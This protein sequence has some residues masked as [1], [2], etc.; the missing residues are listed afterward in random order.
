[1]S[2]VMAYSMFAVKLSNEIPVQSECIPLMGLFL[3][4][5]SIF[6]LFAMIWFI[7]LN[8]FKSKE[9]LPKVLSLPGDCLQKIVCLCFHKKIKQK[10]NMNQVS[11]SSEPEQKINLEDRGKCRFCSNES[12]PENDKTKMKKILDS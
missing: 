5:S 6:N 10:S 12:N 8:Y 1:M 4:I 11:N 7:I 3:L 2:V 9:Y